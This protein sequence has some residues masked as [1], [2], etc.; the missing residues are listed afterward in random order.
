MSEETRVNDGVLV[1]FEN[2]TAASNMA[3]GTLVAVNT[4]PAAQ[5]STTL[6]SLSDNTVG[7]T[8]SALMGYHFIGVLDE[9]VSAGQ[10]PVTVLT[11]GVFKMFTNSATLTANMVIGTPVFGSEPGTVSVGVGGAVS[12]IAIGSLVGLCGS[13]TLA[14]GA[15]V[16]VKIKPGAFR[17]TIWQDTMAAGG[18]TASAPDALLYPKQGA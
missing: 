9:S 15:Y 2:C 17:W 3:A 11:E 10:S 5:G 13:G 7:F 4:S 1:T 8:S 18:T 6:F 12:D 16:L 14:T